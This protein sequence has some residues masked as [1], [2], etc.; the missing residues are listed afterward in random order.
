[1][2]RGL[3]KNVNTATTIAFGT[4][5]V[6]VPME[7]SFFVFNQSS[8]DVEVDFGIHTWENRVGAKLA[9]VGVQAQ[10]D[11]YVKVSARYICTQPPT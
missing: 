9:D 1:M 5:P 7:K 10:A 6:N 4:V 3:H 8:F 11:G 2:I